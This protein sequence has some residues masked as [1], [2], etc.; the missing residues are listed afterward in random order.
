MILQCLVIGPRL[1]LQHRPGAS[2]PLSFLSDS[3]LGTTNVR[4]RKSDSV[5]QKDNQF[6]IVGLDKKPAT[7]P[8]VPHFAAPDRDYTP[9]YPQF[10]STSRQQS[11]SAKNEAETDRLKAQVAELTATSQA[12]FADLTAQIKELKEMLAQQVKNAS[13]PKA[14]SA[15]SDRHMPV[16]PPTPAPFPFT[17]RPRRHPSTSQGPYPYFPEIR[18]T[19][20]DG[21]RSAGPPLPQE[22]PPPPSAHEKR[23]KMS[24]DIPPSVPPYHTLPSTG[25][26][27]V[28]YEYW[29]RPRLV[30]Q[31]S[32][33]LLSAS[34]QHRNHTV[35]IH[36]YTTM[37]PSMQPYPGSSP[38][39]AQ[40]D[41]PMGT[42]YP[43]LSYTLP[44]SGYQPR[45][46]HPVYM[47][48]HGAPS[49]LDA[50]ITYG[51]QPLQQPQQQQSRKSLYPRDMYA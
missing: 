34:H 50:P 10:V 5:L 40:I 21:G 43:R 14:P 1:Y 19:N 41:L 6:F 18:A 16:I 26:P 8:P 51:G 7:P 12:Q 38:Y 20:D 25:P 46:S 42:A 22:F 45:Y 23:P 48:H 2:C 47:G 39:S 28:K 17:D 27:P 32:T 13:E 9:T 4:L 29:P 44:A 30:S 15:Y 24:I 11:P 37:S 49:P 35:P 33:E 31:Q 3:M 36:H